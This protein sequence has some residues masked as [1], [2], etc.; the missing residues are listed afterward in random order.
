MKFKVAGKEYELKFGMKFVRQLDILYKIDYQGLELG[1]GLSMAYMGLAQYSPSV[2]SNI[3]KAAVAHEEN[4]K[5]KTI[6]EAVEEY[7]EENGDLGELFEDLKEEMGK[8]PVVKFTLN[9]M[10]QVTEQQMQAQGLI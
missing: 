7:A 10:N 8:S 2:I 9:K 5:L 3:I 1:A 6:D 4:V